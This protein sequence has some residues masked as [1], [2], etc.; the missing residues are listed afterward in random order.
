MQ[1]RHETPE[2]RAYQKDLQKLQQHADRAWEMFQKLLGRTKHIAL[3]AETRFP[4]DPV[5]QKKYFIKL[6][7]DYGPVVRFLNTYIGTEK[8]NPKAASW[9]RR[10]LYQLRDLHLTPGYP[11]AEAERVLRQVSLQGFQAKELSKDQAPLEVLPSEIKALLP[12]NI[13]VQV[14]EKGSITKMSDRFSNAHDTLAKKIVQMRELT[15]RYNEIVQ[16]VKKDLRGSDEL[17][18]LSALITAIIM[19]TGIRPGKIG[20]GFTKIV[21]GE[22]ISV[23]TFGAI[24]LGPSHVRFIR[25]NFAEL[26]FPGKKG[27]VNLATLSDPQ[28]IKLLQQYVDKALTS[29]LPFVFVTSKGEQY[30]YKHFQ[31]Y[32]RTRVLSG[33][34]P[35]DFRKLKATQ[36]VLEHLNAEQKALY[37]RINAFAETEVEGLKERITQEVVQVVQEAYEK[38][39]RALSHETS[40]TTIEQYINPEVVLRFL[41]HGKIEA[42]LKQ[43][44]LQQKPV[45]R[46]DPEIF[47][48]QAKRKR[49]QAS[50]ALKVLAF[51]RYQCLS[52]P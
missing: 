9:R 10:T 51:W 35:S 15:E 38:A 22:E 18:R 14:D 49:K 5:Q 13:V 19:E 11:L 1:I 17:T 7:K 6:V 40:R 41:S 3:E 50:Q 47:I 4:D 34:A 33:I 27:G 52:S 29:S 21:E 39:T 30:G 28:V 46:F 23:D 2:S 32:F 44:I 31:R 26:V 42:N 37:Q 45:L 24:T 48:R 36:A 20:Q 8:Q 43:A 25:K 12:T 16:K